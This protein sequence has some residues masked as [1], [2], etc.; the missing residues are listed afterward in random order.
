MGVYEYQG[1]D[2]RGA[3]RKGVLNADTVRQAR[4]Q[5]RELGLIPL[6]VCRVQLATGAGAPRGKESHKVHG[7]LNETDLAVITRQFATLLG[8]DLTVEAAL[9]IMIKQSSAHKIKS[10]LGGVRSLVI[11]GHT[12]AD[13]LHQYPRVFD[14]LY[15]A[16]IAAGEET[17]Q[18]AS[19]M[20]RLSEYHETR[21]L[22]G[23]RISTAL[24]YPVLL[25]VMAILIVIGLLTYVVPQVVRVFED[26][27]QTLPLLTRMLIN[28]SHFLRQYGLVLLLLLALLGLAVRLLLAQPGQRLRLHRAYL[29]TPG[30]WRLSS[31]LNVSRMARTLAILSGS[32]VSLLPAMRASTGVMN[33]LALR[34]ALEQATDEVERGGSMHSA[35]Q[36]SQVFPPLLVQMVASGEASG[37]LA[38]MLD[39]A[40]SALERELEAR[41]TVLVGLFEPLIILLMGGVV[42][43]IVL[44]ILLPIFDLN[45]LIGS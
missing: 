19:V 38:H 45:K 28:S 21:Q 25:S 12:L 30:L 32:G 44:A 27:G 13:A 18:L 37:R 15:V 29:S 41:L 40:A 11:D 3:T 1:M 31:G 5:L 16:T 34:Q 17:G 23:Q 2:S 7:R 43:T 24:I 20:E 36:Q 42:M 9:T 4:Q 22:M 26:T 33:N 10:I 39:K 8:S 35:L 6:T 14:E